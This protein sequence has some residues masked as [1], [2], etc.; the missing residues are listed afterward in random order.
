MTIMGIALVAAAGHMIQSWTTYA[1]RGTQTLSDDDILASYKI[2]S[3]ND[4]GAYL[5][6]VLNLWR[7]TGIGGDKIEGFVEVHVT[8]LVQAKLSVEYFGACYIGVSLPDTNYLRALG[9]N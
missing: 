4:T 8:N 6:D 1:D 5:L 2:V 7:K 9:C 3:P